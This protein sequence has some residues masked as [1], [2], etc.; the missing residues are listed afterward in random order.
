M[1]DLDQLLREPPREVPDDGFTAK[2]MVGIAQ[3]RIRRA[4]LETVSLTA[5]VVAVLALLPFTDFGKMLQQQML[6]LDNSMPLALTLT[7]LV[8][9]AALLRYVED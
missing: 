7:A 9:C 8:L 6:T 3:A 4:R 5:G 2:I 1:S